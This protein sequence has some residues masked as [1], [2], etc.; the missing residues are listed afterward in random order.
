MPLYQKQGNDGYFIVKEFNPFWLRISEVIRKL[1]LHKAI[2]W[3][4]GFKKHSTDENTLLINLK[5]ARWYVVEFMH[6]MGYRKDKIVNNK[7]VV[8]KRKYDLRN[9]DKQELISNFE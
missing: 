4:P 7:L 8:S 2:P 3:L 9:P 5:V 6:L 1:G